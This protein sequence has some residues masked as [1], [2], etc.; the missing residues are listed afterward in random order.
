MS[1]DELHRCYEFAASEARTKDSCVYFE[2]AFLAVVEMASRNQ[3]LLEALEIRLI[4]DVL[5]PPANWELVEFCVHVLRPPGLRT[6]VASLIETT[7]VRDDIRH[8]EFRDV[9]AAFD[10][11]WADRDMYATFSAGSRYGGGPGGS[12]KG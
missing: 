2:P 5:T 8:A 10:D 4:E 6:V 1:I 7:P 3:Q 9:L 12:E 11:E